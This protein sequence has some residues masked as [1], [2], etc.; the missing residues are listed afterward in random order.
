MYVL[1]FVFCLFIE[2]AFP[3]FKGIIG[4]FSYKNCDPF[5]IQISG[6]NSIT[7][8]LLICNWSNP[9]ESLGKSRQIPFIVAAEGCYLPSDG[10]VLFLSQYLT[11]FLNLKIFFKPV[12]FIFHVGTISLEMP[13]PVAFKMLFSGIILM[14]SDVVSE[15][16]KYRTQARGCLW[17]PP[18]SDRRLG[19]YCTSV[20]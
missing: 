14:S 7:F 17:N 20:T 2:Y 5:G 1:G 10:Q 13:L 18:Y 11:N 19:R 8:Y 6:V 4:H 3:C 15:G 9:V 16:H 12:L